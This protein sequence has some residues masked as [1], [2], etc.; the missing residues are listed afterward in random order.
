MLKDTDHQTYYPKDYRPSLL[1][2]GWLNLIG[3][4]LISGSLFTCVYLSGCNITY[5][6]HFLASFFIFL[7][8]CGLSWLCGRLYSKY[9]SKWIQFPASC[10]ATNVRYGSIENFETA[11]KL[12]LISEDMGG[13]YRDED[14]IIL[15]SIDGERRCSVENFSFEVVHHNAL[16]NF[17]KITMDKEEIAF[18]PQYVGSHSL[19]LSSAEKATWGY[20]CIQKMA[21]PAGSTPDPDPYA[22]TI[23]EP[24]L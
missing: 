7:I 6:F 1:L 11:T 13:I 16:I 4:V 19:R 20:E 22:N 18:Y 24:Y 14:Q 5:A 15:G 23:P 12:K 10:E 21:R 3:L 8:G 9:N 2:L 17:I